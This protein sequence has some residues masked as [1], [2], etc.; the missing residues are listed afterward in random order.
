[1][2]PTEEE[3]TG[4]ITMEYALAG[5]E[6]DP[7]TVKE[8]KD[9]E[10]WPEWRKAMDTEMLQLEERG[11]FKLVELPPDRSAITSKWVYRLKKDHI[12]EIIKHKVHVVAKGCSQIPGLDFLETF[13]PVM[14]LETFR[15]L[16]AIGTELGLVVHVVDGVG[17]YLN[18]KIEEDTFLMQ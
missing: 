16:I 6:E 7:T 4:C 18:G 17:A 13:A 5:A 9:R 11:T 14:R 2:E 15:L 3:E 10:D 8:A 12:G 1:M